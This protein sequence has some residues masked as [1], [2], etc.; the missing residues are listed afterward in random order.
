MKRELIVAGLVLV[1]LPLLLVADTSDKD[2]ILEFYWEAAPG[3]VD[4]Y[5]IYVSV[6]GE[7]FQQVGETSVLPTVD[8]PYE[9][10]ITAT[11]GNMYV[12]QVEAEDADGLKG[13]MSEPSEPVWKKPG[14]PVPVEP[15]DSAG[16]I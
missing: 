7:E 2:G 5:N 12:V 11:I 10:P 9:L 15:S 13:P 4:H 6:N 3:N 14:L 16:S 8:Y 1:I